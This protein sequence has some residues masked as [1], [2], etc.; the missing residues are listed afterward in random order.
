MCSFAYLNDLDLEDEGGPLQFLL[1]MSL[2]NSD[3]EDETC[4]INP[5]QISVRNQSDTLDRIFM[6][7]KK[8][9]IPMLKRV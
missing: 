5:M 1:T 2:G 3:A 6:W 7:S 9:I 8:D 4:F